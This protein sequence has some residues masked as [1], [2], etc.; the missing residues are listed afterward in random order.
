MMTSSRCGDRPTCHGNFGTA[1]LKLHRTQSLASPAAPAAF[2][3]IG[4]GVPLL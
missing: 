4:R 3:R 1:E 2:K